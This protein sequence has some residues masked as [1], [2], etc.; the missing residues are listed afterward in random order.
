MSLTIAAA[1][2]AQFGVG[3]YNQYRS[4][5]STE[6]LQEAQRDYERDLSERGFAAARSRYERLQ[7]VQ[8]EIEEENHR[9]RLSAIEESLDHNLD[10]AAYTRSLDNWALTVP[11]NVIKRAALS[12][13]P[14]QASADNHQI[15]LHCILTLG[16]DPQFNDS[17]FKSLEHAIQSGINKNWGTLSSHPVVFFSGA[18]AEQR[19]D[20]G[21]MVRNLHAQLKTLPTLVITPWINDDSP[22]FYFKIS[23]WGIDAT[24]PIFEERYIPSDL[25]YSYKQQQKEYTNND[26]QRILAELVLHLQAFIGF[27]ADQYYWAFYQTVP[28][29]PKLQPIVTKAHYGT[30][31]QQMIDRCLEHS[32]IVM[33][34][35]DAMLEFCN[36]LKDII[37]PKD[38]QTLCMRV[39]GSVSPLKQQTQL[40][41]QPNLISRS[42]ET[43]G[44]LPCPYDPNRTH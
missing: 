38:Q 7:S 19:V 44:Q 25:T 18:S 26:C 40:E 28:Q 11:P 20:I 3:L 4:R 15:P 23:L 41:N 32:E 42:N 13:R 6:H 16:N 30:A 9:A 37:P 12:I 31:Y 39:Q 27:I 22:A 2:V 43:H 5:K 29:L 17:I 24:K 14:P 21:V 10:L 35:P 8:H 33:I 1:I 34:H 36:V